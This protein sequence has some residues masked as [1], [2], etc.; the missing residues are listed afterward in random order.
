ME[1]NIFLIGLAA[2]AGGMATALLGWTESG[3]AWDGKKFISSVIRALVGG[4]AIAV[5]MDYSGASIPIVYLMAFLSGAGVE[6]GGNRIAG[7]I[8]AR[9]Q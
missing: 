3:E 6:V 7:A 8:A 1:I 5:A 9:K 2:F 4:I